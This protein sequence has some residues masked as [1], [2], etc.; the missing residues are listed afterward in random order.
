[1]DLREQI[2]QSGLFDEAFYRG[3]SLSRGGSPVTD[4]LQHYRKHGK[5]LSPHPLFDA[6]YYVA[7]C[8]NAASATVSLLEHYLATWRTERVSPHPLLD[9]NAYLEWYPEVLETGLDPLSH[10][11]RSGATAGYN[12]HP[13]FDTEFYHRQYP[14]VKAAAINPLVHYVGR[15]GFEGRDPNPWFDSSYYLECNPDVAHARINP[16]IHYVRWGAKEDRAPHPLF[17]RDHWRAVRGLQ[18]DGP[19]VLADFLS[20][21]GPPG[22]HPMGVLQ[23][24]R[25]RRCVPERVAGVPGVNLIGW[26]RMEMGVAEQLREMARSLMAAGVNVSARDVSYM[27][28]SDPGDDSIVE[29]LRQDCPHRVNLFA[30]N[31]DNMTD[32]CRRLSFEELTHRFNIGSWHWELAEFPD[33]WRN[34]FAVLDELWLS[35]TFM[36]RAISL[37]SDVPVLYMPPAVTLPP[38]AALD[39][40][41]FGIP[42][43]R[44]VFL[45]LFDF[46]GFLTRKNPYA[47]LAAFRSAFLSHS[48]EAALVIKTNN[49]SRYPEGLRELR[50][51][52]GNDP[53]VVLIHDRMR[54]SEITSL[55]SHADAFVSLHRAEGFG[56]SLAESMLLGKPVI[57]TNYSANTDFMTPA[58]SCPVN[59]SLIP[60]KPGEYPFSEGQVWADADVEHAAWYM[61]RLVQN[62]DYRELIGE[63]ARD[64]MIH[65]FSPEVTGRRCLRRLQELGLA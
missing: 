4:A 36:Q 60:I 46:T 27:T 18:D 24:R 6:D 43:S 37:K 32:A 50:E 20:H 14:D 65:D 10:F 33:A 19:G 55:L 12:P 30:I 54:R 22:V 34:E 39:R 51:A 38:S 13:L 5:R 15:G 47:A 63:A 29:L 2:L 59:Y 56:R 62:R 9:L 17:R 21:A 44:F 16:L 26:P 28:S 48:T 53:R 52:V 41:H 8:P 58:N 40:S 1:M 3:A 7:I 35:S 49:A 64:T 11:L 23:L 42:E 57:G 61:R 25:R 45:F 31:A